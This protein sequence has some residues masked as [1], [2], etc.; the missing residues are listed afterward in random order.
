MF[1]VIKTGG[2]Q[3]RVAED[4]VLQIEK[5]DG[6]PGNIVQLG[7]VLMIGGDQ[8]QIGSPASNFI[9]SLPSA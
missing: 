8:P 3:Y 2:K 1:A 6:E 4:Q 9:V 7:N 5:I